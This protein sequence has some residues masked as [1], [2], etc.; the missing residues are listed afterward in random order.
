M[1]AAQRKMLRDTAGCEA[2]GRHLY[3]LPA[4]REMSFDIGFFVVLD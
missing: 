1:P 2:G 4:V 3:R